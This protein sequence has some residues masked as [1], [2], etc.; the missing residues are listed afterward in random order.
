L[1]GDEVT[2]VTSFKEVRLV[3]RKLS[4][5]SIKRGVGRTDMS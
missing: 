4:S 5:A 2:D 1:F 3:S